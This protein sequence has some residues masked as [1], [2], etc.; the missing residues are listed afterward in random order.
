MP[1]H[2]QVIGGGR[3][4][5]SFTPEQIKPHFIDIK[6]NGEPVKGCPIMCKVSDTSHISL[7]L[8]HLEFMGVNEKCSFLI[9][10]PNTYNQ[11]SDKLS[12][13]V[14][15]AHNE[16]PVKIQGNVHAGF[17]VE[18]TPVN[19]GAHQIFV[20]FNDVSV[21]GTPFLAK[22]FDVQKIQIGH[23]NNGVVGAPVT[24]SVD[25]SES[26]EGNLEITISSRGM[27][28]MFVIN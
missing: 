8:A 18:F 13:S 9:N 25:A 2:V 6:F 28:F 19:V 27:F 7:N 12:V 16:L 20:E 10:V 3:C 17:T 11:N 5:V 26:G 15:D 21:N 14:R 1:N 4:L 24:F 23:V 22:A